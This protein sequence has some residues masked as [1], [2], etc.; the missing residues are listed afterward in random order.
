MSFSQS[1][2]K[3]NLDIHIE[4]TGN[5]CWWVCNSCGADGQRTV[6]R[7][8]GQPQSH[9]FA[10]PGWPVTTPLAG[11]KGSLLESWRKHLE[12]SHPYVLAWTTEE[13][14]LRELQKA[15]AAAKDDSD[16]PDDPPCRLCGEPVKRFGSVLWCDACIDDFLSQNTEDIDSYVQR[17]KKE[18]REREWGPGR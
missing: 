10:F 9:A 1:D 2:P 7:Q 11:V 8:M 17:K 14:R 6:Q 4:E 12:T 16:I 5:Y 3:N 15:D 13:E 18:Q